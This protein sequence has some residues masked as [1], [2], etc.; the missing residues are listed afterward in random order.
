MF[1]IAGTSNSPDNCWYYLI[2]KQKTENILF[3]FKTWQPVKLLFSWILSS[4]YLLNAIN[5]ES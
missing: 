3:H 4:I 1:L 5:Q 2:L